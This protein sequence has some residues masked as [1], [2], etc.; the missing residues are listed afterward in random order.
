MNK[1]IAFMA[2]IITKAKNYILVGLTVIG[3]LVGGAILLNQE[4]IPNL[5]ALEW[6]VLVEIYN[7]ELQENPVIEDVRTKA[8]I[9]DKLDKRILEKAQGREQD[10]KNLIEG[11]LIKR[12]PKNKEVIK[13]LRK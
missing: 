2:K 9:L 13:N 12:N 8:D 1:V 10:E 4:D 5:T 3:L 6:R 11:L 7:E